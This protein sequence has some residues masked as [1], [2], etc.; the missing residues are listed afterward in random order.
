[1]KV[2]ELPYISQNENINVTTTLIITVF[3]NLHLI[4]RHTEILLAISPLCNLT[5]AVFLL[6]YYVFM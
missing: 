2:N 3:C 5:F 1:M 6:N 4:L